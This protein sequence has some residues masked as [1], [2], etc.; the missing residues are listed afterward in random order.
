MLRSIVWSLIRATSGK[1]KRAISAFGL[2]TTL[3]PCD[4]V[5]REEGFVCSSFSSGQYSLAFPFHVES[6]KLQKS[7]WGPLKRKGLKGR[8]DRIWSNV[9]KLGGLF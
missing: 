9:A 4:L 8:I 5:P 3:A 7:F 1:R 2:S 6:S